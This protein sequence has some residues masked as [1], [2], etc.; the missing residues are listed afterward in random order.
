MTAYQG[1]LCPKH[2]VR[3]Q[4][5]EARQ[6]EVR[7]GFRNIL[8]AIDLVSKLQCPEDGCDEI[9]FTDRYGVVIDGLKS[10]P[11]GAQP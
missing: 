7:T 1:V 4:F 3:Y 5:V 10:F 2:H 9:I 11:K 6:V 8:R